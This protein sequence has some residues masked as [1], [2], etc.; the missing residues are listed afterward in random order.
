MPVANISV[1]AV[2]GSNDDLP[3]STL[4][5]LANQDV[6]GELAYLW[7]ILDQPAGSADALSNTTIANPT[8]TPKKEGTYLV[9]LVVNQSLGTESTD[10]VV[11]AVRFLKS[12]ERAPAAGETTQA[13]LTRGWAAALDLQLSRS[14]AK[15][16]LEA[17]VVVGQAGATLAKGDVVRCTGVA[18]I[19]S[20]LP[21][22]EDVPIFNKALATAAGNVDELLG[23]V[24]GT[25]AGASSTTVGNLIRVRHFG[26]YSATVAGAPASGDPVFVSDLG[27]LALAAGTST[28][29]VGAAVAP[30]GGSYRVYF[31]GL[32]AD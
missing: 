25:P 16:N 12:R 2:D 29:K 24:E 32:R 20:G 19:K 11:V 8:F 13:H 28:R 6:G 7:A 21:G 15:Y 17:G 27:A 30:A 14:D 22:A 1:N 18:T 9:K 3:I 31:F 23:V 26:L 10:V 4:V 5:Q